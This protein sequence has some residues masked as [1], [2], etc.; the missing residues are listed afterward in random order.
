MKPV[1]TMMH[2]QKNIKLCLAVFEIWGFR[3]G[4]EK[5][6]FWD[7]KPVGLVNTTDVYKDLWESSSPRF[8]VT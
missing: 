3:A 1:Y 8:Y 4:I 5:K 6:F 2:G 7:M